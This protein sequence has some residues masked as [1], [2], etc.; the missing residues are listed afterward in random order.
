MNKTVAFIGAGNMGGAIVRA[1]C[2]AIDP[3]QAVIFNP[4]AAKAEALSRETGCCVASSGREAAGMAKYVMLCVKPQVLPDVLRD[5]LPTL[6]AAAD[7]G[8]RQ[9]LVSIAA[10]IQLAAL[11]G[12][13]AEGG[14]DLP[15]IRIMPNT[16]VAIGKGIML[17][18][19]SGRVSE[20]DYAGLEAILPQCGLL[21]RTTERYLDMGSAVAGCGPAFVYLF[22]EALADGGVQIG[23]PRAKAQLYAAQMVSGA[24]EMVLQSGQHPGA[25]KD[26]VCSPGGTTIV[27]VAELENRGFRAAAAQA[28]VAAYNKN[29]QLSK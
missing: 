9:V 11:S 10:G 28:V 7:A 17:M 26:A 14:L 20:A 13:L 21:E 3:A 19:A 27:G 16:P 4:T 25:L 5:L 12:L 1:V 6:R 23:L 24:A 8:E 2:R 18:T 29:S 15:V 22:I